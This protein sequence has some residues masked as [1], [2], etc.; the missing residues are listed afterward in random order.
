MATLG[1]CDGCETEL[2]PIV[3]KDPVYGFYIGVDCTCGESTQRISDYY[4]HYQVAD[5]HLENGTWKLTGGVV[6]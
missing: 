6:L 2:R 1:R 3:L 5:R 4:P